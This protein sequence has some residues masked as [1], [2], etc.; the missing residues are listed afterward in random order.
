[1]IGLLSGAVRGRT[2]RIYG[3][4]EIG[5]SMGKGK[6]TRFKTSRYFG[7]RIRPLRY[8]QGWLDEKTWRKEGRK[9]FLAWRRASRFKS[10]VL[11]LITICGL[12]AFC[13]TASQFARLLPSLAQI[14][15]HEPRSYP[16]CRMR[17]AMCKSNSRT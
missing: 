4:M 17:H 1:M 6:W 13:E 15:R 12:W 8:Q 7:A 5:H 11:V 2:M 16:N 9:E 3:F 10:A 14:V